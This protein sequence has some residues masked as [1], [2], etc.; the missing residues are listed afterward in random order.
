M[1][2][3]KIVHLLAS[4]KWTGPAEGV[5]TLC[6][7]LRSRGHQVR[8]F[9][10]P[11][12]RPLLADQAIKRGIQP[13]TGL[14]LAADH[15]VSMIRDIGR[16]RSILKKGKPDILHLHLS[17]D[18][19][20][21]ALA[22][23]LAGGSTRVIRTIHHVDSI[24]RR[25][26]RSR[27]YQSMTDGFITLDH[28]TREDLC[29]QYR[30]SAVPVEVI[31]GAVDTARF[32]PGV[33]PRL[34]RAEFGI[35]NTSP[36]MGLVA[37]FQS[38][39]RHELMIA[40]FTRIQKRLPTVRLLLVGRGEYQPFI[41]RLVQRERIANRVLFTGYRDHDLPRVYAAMDAVI[42]LAA[43]SDGSC[44]AALEAMAMGRPVVGFPVGALPETIQEGV[45]GYLVG[46]GLVEDLAECLVTLLSDRSRNQAMGEASRKRIESEFT[47]AYRLQ[48]TEMFYQSLLGK[49]K[50]DSHGP[51][52]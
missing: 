12:A 39:R 5:V 35:P 22:A 15:P 42:F 30:L 9:S 44:R 2:N 37:R 48:K 33:D 4:H 23:R 52:G 51:G 41:E 27:I 36:V 32:H 18:H 25:L 8:L 13:E 16:L 7:D 26:F 11:H 28:R 43:G 49:S 21:G 47:E 38:H 6:R 3:L 14:R 29:R 40:A 19:A 45:T 34:T 31:H 1:S 10:T 20:I 50:G 46:D 24:R 17:T